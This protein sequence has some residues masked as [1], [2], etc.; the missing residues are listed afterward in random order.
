MNAVREVSDSF[1]GHDGG[2]WAAVP[3]RVVASWPPGHFAEN[4]AIDDTGTVFVSL[5]SHNR[6]DRYD[7]RTD[8]VDT[9]ARLHARA[10]DLA[11]DLDGTLWAT[12]GAVGDPPGYLWRIVAG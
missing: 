11:F 9:F 4:L 7:P 12:G 3:S 2:R 8:A 6:V 1:P 5:H 10:T